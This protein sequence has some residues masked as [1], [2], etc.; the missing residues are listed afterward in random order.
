MATIFD[1]L[2][3]ANI[4][5]AMNGNTKES[6]HTDRIDRL[7][8]DSTMLC[9]AN[10][11]VNIANIDNGSPTKQIMET[12]VIP[13]PS[14]ESIRMKQPFGSQEDKFKENQSEMKEYHTSPMRFPYKLEISEMSSFPLKLMEAL[15]NEDHKE[16]I[17]WLAHGRG[18]MI[19]QTKE[20]VEKVMPKYFKQTKF[21]SF[22][23]KLSRWGFTRVQRGPEVGVYYH[24]LFLRDNPS[25]C[26]KMRS[27]RGKER[28]LKKITS[29]SQDKKN[30]PISPPSLDDSKEN[31]R[32][33]CADQDTRL[34]VDHSD[35]R[36]DFHTRMNL[37]IPQSNII[38][39]HESTQYRRD[40]I[41]DNTKDILRSLSGNSCLQNASSSFES[42]IPDQNVIQELAMLQGVSHVPN[43]QNTVDHNHNIRNNLLQNLI[44]TVNAT[45]SNTVPQSLPDPA[46]ISTM[47]MHM[48][49]NI[50]IKSALQQIGR[51]LG[52]V[53]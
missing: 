30:N 49:R 31:A 22:T 13:Q 26:L 53:M 38:P 29:D 52:V 46:N 36:N 48:A 28:K 43:L 34:H 27:L 20:F 12:K 35:T 4:Q 15:S 16:I 37:N 8:S 19:F 32:G 33:D 50:L 1:Q 14:F 5:T 2:N 39:P 17:S 10:T 3:A 40:E 44:Q 7:R 24:D 25:L 21:P 42:C 11:L 45:Q 41:V 18:F 51:D 47:K 6:P 23:R 9:V